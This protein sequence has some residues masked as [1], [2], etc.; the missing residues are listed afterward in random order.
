MPVDQPLDSSATEYESTLDDIIKQVERFR[1]L[2]IGR[3]G[4]GK[5]SLINC[6]FGIDNARVEDQKVGEADIE[7]EFVSTQNQYFVL[8]DSKGFEPGDLSNF[9]IVRKF[10]EDR[11][12]KHLLKDRIHA[13]WLCTETPTAGGRVFETGDERLLQFAHKNNGTFS[14]FV[15]LLFDWLM[16]TKEMQLRGT[17]MDAATKS[18]QS[19]ENA[20]EAFNVTLKSLQ[21]T[22]DHLEIPMPTYAKVSVRKGYEKDV[23]Y[24]VRVTRDVAR[25]QVTGDAWVLWSMAQ[26]ASLPDKIEA[27]II[28]SDPYY[29]TS[30][31]IPFSVDEVNQMVALATSVSTSIVPAFA[32]MG[33]ATLTIRWLSRTL[34]QNLSEAQ[35]L[36]V[37]YIVDLIKVLIELFN[38][39]IRVELA[40]T[41]TWASL[42]EAFEAYDQSSSR[43]SIHDSIR[44]KKPMVT[45]GEIRREIRRL[46]E[47]D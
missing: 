16:S 14:I 25:E 15:L 12:K 27:C 6:V 47:V 32:A 2:V 18:R 11:S 31:D 44:S 41:T 46:L 33:L 8:H 5:S 22:M 20:Q 1:I 19:V 39:T 9:D 43:Q 34:G 21:L 4:V 45:T 10:V 42:Q 40:L 28:E 30:F 35:R 23:S 29:L 36:L 3:S 13:L 26:R 24:L 38:I 17:D 37:A 7:Q